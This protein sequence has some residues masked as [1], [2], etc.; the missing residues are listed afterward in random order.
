MDQ[1]VKRE[2]SINDFEIGKPLGR[3]KF[4]RVYVA[5]EA[6]VS[7]FPHF[8]CLS[9]LFFIWWDFILDRNQIVYTQVNLH[10]VSQRNI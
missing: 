9:V 10:I 5:R 2:W 8:C 7:N 6:K 4:G 1:T 3:G